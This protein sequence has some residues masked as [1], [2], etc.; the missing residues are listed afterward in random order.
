M[1]VPEEVMATHKRTSKH[2]RDAWQ[3]IRHRLL[4]NGICRGMFQQ[5]SAYRV[6]PAVDQGRKSVREANDSGL[7]ACCDK[8]ISKCT[9]IDQVFLKPEPDKG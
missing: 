2:L 4:A 9:A 8:S 3:S 6:Y 1:A 5:D 7:K